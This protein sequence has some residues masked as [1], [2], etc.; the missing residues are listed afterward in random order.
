MGLKKLTRL[1]SLN[2]YHCYNVSTLK[3]ASYLTTLKSLD[4]GFCDSMSIM[5]GIRDVTNLHQLEVLKCQFYFFDN[6]K[7]FDNYSA[8]KH[9]LNM[10]QQ[11]VFFYFYQIYSC[12]SLSKFHICHIICS[13]QPP[14]DRSTVTL[15]DFFR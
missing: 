2:V 1:N 14:L 6:G 4:C 11:T 8:L 7:S 13:S 10:L 5:S 15:Y 9:L 3:I 12:F